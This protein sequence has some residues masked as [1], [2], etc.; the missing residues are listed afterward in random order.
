MVAPTVGQ[1]RQAP[2]GRGTR[3]SQANKPVIR[4]PEGSQWSSWPLYLPG[5]LTEMQQPRAA[6]GQTRC[7][8]QNSI[9]TVFRNPESFS[10]L[11]PFCDR[12]N[13]PLQT[14]AAAA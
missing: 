1:R 10:L 12:R 4:D 5:A 11:D 8:S 9:R 14:L 3:I 2:A 6:S 7:R 13:R